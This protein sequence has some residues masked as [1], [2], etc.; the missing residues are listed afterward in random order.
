MLMN[1]NQCYVVDVVDADGVVLETR[2]GD[3][4]NMAAVTGAGALA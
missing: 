1:R 4:S 3:E 2:V